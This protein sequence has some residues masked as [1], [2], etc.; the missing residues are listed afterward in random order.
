VVG[1]A[2]FDEEE[3]FVAAGDGAAGRGG[4]VGVEGEGAPF[5]SDVALE[6]SF[7]FVGFGSDVVDPWP[8]SAVYI[9]NNNGFKQKLVSPVPSIEGGRYKKK[10]K[11]SGESYLQW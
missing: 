10:K 2:G 7:E 4:E 1:G 8:L 9:E 11:K 3:G 6:V 5:G